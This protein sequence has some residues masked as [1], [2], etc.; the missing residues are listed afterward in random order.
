[1]SVRADCVVGEHGL[2]GAHR[3][4]HRVDSSTTNTV[5]EAIA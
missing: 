1:M 4:V 2:G 5:K 3:R